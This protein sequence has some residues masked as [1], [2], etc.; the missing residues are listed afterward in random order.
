MPPPLPPA[1]TASSL[2][3]SPQPQ[4]AVRPQPRPHQI[5]WSA[6]PVQQH[7][8]TSP[9]SASDMAFDFG[10]NSAE[11]HVQPDIV[12]IPSPTDSG[13]HSG[14]LSPGAWETSLITPTMPPPSQ[15]QHALQS[16]GLPTPTYSSSRRGSIAD[17]L[18]NTFEGFA[19]A[20]GTA[21]MGFSTTGSV[22][23]EA[24][25]AGT[26]LASRRRR[27]RPADLKSASLRS[28][29]YGALTA[30]SPTFRQGM[31]ST[32]A[33]ALRHVKSTGHGLNSYG[34]IRKSSIPQK[35]PLNVS[36]FA[37]ADFQQLMARKAAENS[38]KQQLTPINT[39]QMT[40]PSSQPQPFHSLQ[41]IVNSDVPLQKRSQV[42]SPPITPY[43]TDFLLHSASMMPP[44]IQAQYASFADFTP[45]YSAGPLTNSSWSDA[46]L[47]SPDLANFPSSNLM[48]SMLGDLQED[49]IHMP[50]TF[51]ADQSP[52]HVVS[53]G[54]DQRQTQFYIQEFPN[55][56]AEHAQAAQQLNQTRPR[57]YAFQ[58]HK[59]EDFISHA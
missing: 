58:H 16:P 53:P 13:S 17:G 18:T 11:S 8:P 31:P 9:P 52:H 15:Y 30:A 5:D 4:V 41:Q 49:H 29:S 46:P 57:H 6:Q 40:F 28:R 42:Q 12:P 54:N 10:F 59:P 56:K 44:A 7:W 48:P 34:G 35:S 24:S 51:S 2:K 45:P 55:Q 19:I 25:D 50:W 3:T 39:T 43:Q 22:S 36:T 32:S 21:A 23:S 47:T 38:L 26:D 27:Q 33:Q 14:I 37:E 20:N 1:H